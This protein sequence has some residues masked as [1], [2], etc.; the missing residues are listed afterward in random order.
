MAQ[1]RLLFIDQ[2]LGG[3]N[4]Y[5]VPKYVSIPLQTSIPVLRQALAA[6]IARHAALRTLLVPDSASGE[7]TQ[8]ILSPD[9]LNDSLPIDEVQLETS[10]ELDQLLD[11]ESRTRFNLSR[12]IPIRIVLA[13]IESPALLVLAFN[14]HHT[15]FDAWSWSIVQHDLRRLYMEVSSQSA[16]QVSF[17]APSFSHGAYADWQ[18]RL[19]EGEHGKALQNY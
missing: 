16:E 13:K 17:A 9:V 14:F 10:Q 11:G 6:L 1:E 15:A 7:I 3:S 2:F 8:R 4:A 19:L 12:E 5:N 18:R